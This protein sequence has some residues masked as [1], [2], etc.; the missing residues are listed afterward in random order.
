[1]KAH[2]E[3]RRDQVGKNLLVAALLEAIELDRAPQQRIIDRF[4]I[5]Q[6]AQARLAFGLHGDV[7]DWEA[8]QPV[9]RVGIE[10][11][12]LD[13]RR[14]VGV[15]RVEQH[16]AKRRLV[17]LAAWSDRPGSGRR[18]YP[19][20]AV[21]GTHRRVIQHRNHLPVPTPRHGVDCATAQAGCVN[22][23]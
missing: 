14:F 5:A 9:A 18:P 8:N 22:E 3:S 2:S 19:G 11:R 7:P 13:D 21:G 1:M 16:T 10:H 4:G 20:C 17:R 23:A 15:V 6:H 12:P